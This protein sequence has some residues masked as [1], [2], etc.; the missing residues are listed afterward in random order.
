MS[1]MKITLK[2]G[3]C[4]C[5]DNI[6]AY[7]HCSPVGTCYACG[8]ELD[9]PALIVLDGLLNQKLGLTPCIG[10]HNMMD[11]TCPNCRAAF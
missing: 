4:G 2:C 3:S 9:K 5:T 6:D 7:L 10:D 1:P 8:A 11:E